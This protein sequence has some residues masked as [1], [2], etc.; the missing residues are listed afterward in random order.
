MYTKEF[1]HAIV[2]SITVM[3]QV[4]TFIDYPFIAPADV[5]AVM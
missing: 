5:L 3:Q 2:E 4:L 1:L